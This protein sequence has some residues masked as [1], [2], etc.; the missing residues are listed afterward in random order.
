MSFERE[1]PGV[2]AIYSNG[3]RRYDPKWQS[4]IVTLCLA[5]GASVSRIALT[6]GVNANLL[7]KW[8]QKH[9]EAQQAALRLP[10][11]S[12]SAFIPVH[13]AP[14]EEDIVLSHANASALELRPDSP[15]M[16]LSERDRS[17]LLS[18]PAKMSVSLPNGVNLSVECS[19][20]RAVTAIIGAV[21]D[22]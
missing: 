1:L 4:E 12:A 15:G 17:V 16:A 20:V 8:I 5:P 18:A 9:R 22:V 7:W 11:S 6:H 14:V 10:G 13:L 3:R 19:D 21:R 2:I